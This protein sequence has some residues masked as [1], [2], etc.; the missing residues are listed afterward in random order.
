L[1]SRRPSAACAR[2][3][4]RALALAPV[5]FGVLLRQNAV[6]AAPVLAAYAA[7]PER[8]DPK[9]TA[10]LLL[11]GALAFYALVPT[12]YYGA[13]HA[14]KVNPLHQILAYDLGGISHFT[15]E[16]QFP[17]SWSAEQ[18][19][20]LTGACYGPERW[21]VYWYVP[22]CSFVMRRLAQPDDVVFGS[23]RL[24]EA[25][26]RAV[27]A[28]P[29]A[30]LGH[31]A[32]FMWNFLGRPNLV[33]PHLDW[34][35][36]QATYG[37]NRYFRPL[38]APHGVLERTPLFRPGLWLVLAIVVVAAAWPARGVPMGAFAV[39]VGAS[40]V[41]YAG[42]FFAVGVAPDFRYAYW[43]VLATLAGGVAAVA[44]R[45]ARAAPAQGRQAEKVGLLRCDRSRRSAL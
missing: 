45:P 40:A 44:A 11:P 35:G 42:T 27:L 21:D 7:W 12:V 33:L 22:P 2:P 32:R 41:A 18:T 17:V 10:I 39:G 13:L 38:L 28:H 25:W 1:R 30:H 34:R 19:A 8:F 3:L 26:R 16:N 36:P 29:A 6:F 43:S 20:L 31:R 9:R 23:P 24:A 37:A 14:K 5:A 15:G 4:L